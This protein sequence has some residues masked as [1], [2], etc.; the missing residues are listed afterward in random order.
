MFSFFIFFLFL[1]LNL[2]DETTTTIGKSATDKTWAI[3]VLYAFFVINPYRKFNQLT[4]PLTAS[5]KD[6]MIIWGTFSL[7]KFPGMSVPLHRQSG[8]LQTSG[9]HGWAGP[10]LRRFTAA[11]VVPL[12]QNRSKANAT[13]AGRFIIMLGFRFC[14]ALLCFK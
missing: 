8:S 10:R 9:E 5:S 4:C 11:P 3:S 1:P 14:D 7:C 6:N 13:F 12:T 2:R